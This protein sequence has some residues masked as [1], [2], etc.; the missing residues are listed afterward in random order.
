MA[1]HAHILHHGSDLET[2]AQSALENAG[3]QWTQMR[4]SVFRMLAANAKPASAYDIAEQ[5]SRQDDR[6]VAANS[7]Y[8]ILDLFVAKNLAKRIESAN[9]YIVNTHPGC[10]HDCIFLVC[11]TCGSTRHVDDDSLSAQVRNIASASGFNPARPIIEVRGAC[12][13]CVGT[14]SVAG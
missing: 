4:S 6:R 8:R 11:D 2:A 9:A 12:A 5:L 1:Q 7:V 13:N 10:Q 3:E 14:Q